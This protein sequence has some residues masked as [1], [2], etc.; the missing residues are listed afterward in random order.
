MLINTAT[1]KTTEKHKKINKNKKNK[2]KSGAPRTRH[3]LSGHRKHFFPL[4]ERRTTITLVSKR[5]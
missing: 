1:V 2:Q 5:F 4:R 3:L